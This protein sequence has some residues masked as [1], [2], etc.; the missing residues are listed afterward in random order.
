MFYSEL[1]LMECSEAEPGEGAGEAAATAQ[2]GGGQEGACVRVCE[3]TPP[4]TLLAGHRVARGAADVNTALLKT[5]P[6]SGENR[7]RKKRG[8]EKRKYEVVNIIFM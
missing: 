5:S 7:R 8:E 3:Y 2:R 1:L 6:S 4:L